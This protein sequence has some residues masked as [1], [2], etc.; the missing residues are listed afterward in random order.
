MKTVFQPP[1]WL[2]PKTEQEVI[3][4][5][6]HLAGLTTLAD[7]VGSRQAWFPYAA[8]ADTRP[9]AARASTRL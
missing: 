7:W 4:L 2:R 5:S 9:T 8:M 6:W 1:T 3:R